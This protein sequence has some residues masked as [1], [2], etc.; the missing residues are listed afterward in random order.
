MAPIP[1][2]VLVS[3]YIKYLGGQ[4][5]ERATEM[6]KGCGTS[7]YMRIGED[8]DHFKYVPWPRDQIEQKSRRRLATRKSLVNIGLRVEAEIP[9]RSNA[10]KIKVSLRI[11][12][13]ESIAERLIAQR[14]CPTSRIGCVA[15]ARPR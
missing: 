1:A 2:L 8:A 4:F 11:A 10:A 3:L 14:K 7:G 15:T 13:T 9:M 12:G 6:A 5:C